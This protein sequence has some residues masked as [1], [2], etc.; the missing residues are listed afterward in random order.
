MSL[1]ERDITGNW[2]YTI[3]PYNICI[4]SDCWFERRDSFNRFRS[5]RLPGLVFGNRVRIYT[6]TT[7]NIEPNGVVEIG[8]NSII[9]GAIFM[10]AERIT[11]GRNVVISYHVSIAD[12]DFHPIDAKLRQ[13]D[14]IANSPGGDRSRRPEFDST[15]VLIED[16]VRIGVNAIILKGA[17]IGKGA[18]VLAGSVVTGDVAAGTTVSGNPARLL[19]TEV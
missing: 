5:Q 17:H 4:G 6:W 18:N 2:D 14:A 13:Q 12:S 16:D 10:C 11:V 8:D 3:L 7:F 15:P 1:D 9:V 19:T